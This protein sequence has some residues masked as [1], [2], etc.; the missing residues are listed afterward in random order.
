VDDHEAAER[1]ALLA[2]YGIKPTMT[3]QEALRASTKRGAWSVALAI[4]SLVLVPVLGF[5]ATFALSPI[6]G[7][8]DLDFQAAFRVALIVIQVI[9]VAVATTGVFL[10][11]TTVVGARRL[12]GGPERTLVV[13]LGVIGVLVGATMCAYLISNIGS[14]VVA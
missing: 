7:A 1:D 13:A 2:R 3:T 8:A 6:G 5:V 4:G 9:A 14:L 11:A 10:G 12:R